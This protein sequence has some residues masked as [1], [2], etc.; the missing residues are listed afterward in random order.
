MDHTHDIQSA[1]SADDAA[2]LRDCLVARPDLVRERDHEGCTPLIVAAR[3]G[4]LEATR[5]L[6]ENGADLEACDPIYNRTPLAWA[7]FHGHSDVVEY[8]LQHGADANATDAYG[9]TPLKTAAM[10][11]EGA[12][13]EWV[14]VAPQQYE[15]V[16][17]L[18][19]H[20]GAHERHDTGMR[21]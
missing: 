11:S 2:R 14:P 21:E 19:R 12:W 6:V 1:V 16:A 8:L 10:G 9:H 5:L 15:S 13:D 4:R 20:H 18:L 3:D 7:A 17:E